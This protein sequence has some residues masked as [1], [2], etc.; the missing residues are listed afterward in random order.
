MRLRLPELLDEH[1]MSPYKLAKLSGGRIHETTAYRLVRQRG[2]VRMIDVNVL[3]ALCD[4][5]NAEPNDILERGKGQGR[6]RR[7]R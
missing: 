6:K 5:F 7:R 1:D 4:I 3:E 2:E